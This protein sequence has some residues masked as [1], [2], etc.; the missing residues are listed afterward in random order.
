MNKISANQI[1]A[2]NTTLSVILGCLAIYYFYNLNA[3]V[4]TWSILTTYLICYCSYFGERK[5]MLIGTILAHIFYITLIA[6]FA[7]LVASLDITSVIVIYSAIIL[8]A[9][10]LQGKIKILANTAVIIVSTFIVSYSFH[11]YAIS[12]EFL[13]LTQT[14]VGIIIGSTLPL[15]IFILLPYRGLQKVV[16]CVSS[17]NVIRGLRTTLGFIILIVVSNKYEMYSFSWA[18]F[19][20]IFVMQ[21]ALGMTTKKAISRFTGTIIGIVIAA[22]MLQVLPHSQ[23][24]Y[25]VILFAS[26][27]IGNALVTINYAYAYTF[28]S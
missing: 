21:G 24:I 6:W 23:Q 10:I 19:S 25:V 7:T 26:L 28:L 22:L 18:G 17:Y 1:I 3:V 2:I 5:I 13:Y 9:Y 8:I 12:A 15:I 16:S 27:A 14:T 4:I 20:F 11:T